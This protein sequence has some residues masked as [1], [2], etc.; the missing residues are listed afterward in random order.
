MTT[1]GE[2]LRQA[3]KEAGFT[4]TELAEL[5]GSA[6]QLISQYENGYCQ[7]RNEELKRNLCDALGV[8]DAW[9]FA[10]FGAQTTEEAQAQVEKHK[11]EQ[12]AKTEIVY[13]AKDERQLRDIEL[14]ISHLKSLDISLNDKRNVHKTLSE[15][16]GELECKVLFGTGEIRGM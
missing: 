13:S 15:I 5:I 6:N 14:V 2:R 10:G 3:R 1:F 4:Q 7:P 9:L 12:K 16:R 8:T 11:A